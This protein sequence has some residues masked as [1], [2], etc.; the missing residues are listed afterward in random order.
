[1]KIF[2]LSESAHMGGDA[3]HNASSSFAIDI[4]VAIR[5]YYEQLEEER[6]YR[7]E[8]RLNPT[9]G[10]TYEAKEGLLTQGHYPYSDSNNAFGPN[11]A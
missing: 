10:G 3:D 9:T 5:R 1:M 11:R 7:H 2:L 6:E 8:F 4:V